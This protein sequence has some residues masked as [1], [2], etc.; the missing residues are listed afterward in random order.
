MTVGG[1]KSGLVDGDIGSTNTFKFERVDHFR[2]LEKETSHED[3]V[4]E[5]GVCS[6]RGDGIWRTLEV[7]LKY[8]EIVDSSQCEGGL[9][10][11]PA[12]LKSDVVEHE[13]LKE[14]NDRRMEMAAREEDIRHDGLGE[15]QIRVVCIV[16]AELAVMK[17]DR[18]PSGL[19]EIH[20]VGDGIGKCARFETSPGDFGVSESPRMLLT[21][22]VMVLDTNIV[23]ISIAYGTMIRRTDTIRPENISSNGGGYKEYRKQKL[24]HDERFACQN[25]ARSRR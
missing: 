13:L 4:E 24:I 1:S 17:L 23:V 9:T 11:K 16:R 7:G 19:G 12:I 2:L 14:Q 10:L 3:L 18:G 5:E 25:T 15:G 21:G 6:R 22:K 20:R 8:F